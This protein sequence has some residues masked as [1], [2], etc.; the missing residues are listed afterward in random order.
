MTDWN[1]LIDTV[2]FAI[3]GSYGYASEHTE[4]YK[5]ARTAMLDAIA[6]VEHERD[7]LTLELEAFHNTLADNEQYCA[8]M[9]ATLN[10]VKGDM[11]KVKAKLADALSC[12]EKLSGVN[13]DLTQKLAEAQADAER[14]YQ[15]CVND[16]IDAF[17]EA[18]R[19]HRDRTGKA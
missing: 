7:A 2:I 4:D 11:R 15:A 17:E 6:A 1:E 13:M 3:E 16:D 10:T 14:Y 12:N 19:L 9:S 5:A 18:Q 8:S